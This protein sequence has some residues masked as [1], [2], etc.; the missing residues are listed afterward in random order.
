[1]NNSAPNAKALGIA[2]GGNDSDL[3]RDGI[4]NGDS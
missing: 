4:A 3:A 1:M 2:D